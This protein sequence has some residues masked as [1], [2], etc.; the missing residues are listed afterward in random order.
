MRQD[1][2][3]ASKPCVSPVSQNALSLNEK[4]IGITYQYLEFHFLLSHTNIPHLRINKTSFCKPMLN[5][6]F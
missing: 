3:S 2:I 1:K 6:D 4:S 5:R